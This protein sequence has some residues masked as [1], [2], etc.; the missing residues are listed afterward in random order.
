MPMMTAVDS[1][2]AWRRYDYIHDD[3]S[4]LVS[5]YC[6]SI[7]MLSLSYMLPGRG[8]IAFVETDEYVNKC[9]MRECQNS[10]T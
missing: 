4:L 6:R 8:H 2:N 9:A 3:V 7:I 10:L 1:E 5:N